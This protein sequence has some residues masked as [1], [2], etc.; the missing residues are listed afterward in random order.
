MCRCPNDIYGSA[1]SSSLLHALGDFSNS[2]LCRPSQYAQPRYC[3]T[4]LP[5]LLVLRFSSVN[6]TKARRRV[7]HISLSVRDHFL[8]CSRRSFLR[9]EICRDTTHHYR[10]LLRLFRREFLHNDRGS[11]DGQLV[12]ARPLCHRCVLEATKVLNWPSHDLFRSARLRC[13][14]KLNRWV[15]QGTSPPSHLSIGLCS[16]HL[17]HGEL[18][19]FANHLHSPEHAV[20]LLARPAAFIQLPDHQPT[21]APSLRREI[22]CAL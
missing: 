16:H 4:S 7:L 12:L 20:C 8:T 2:T 6:R 15:S 1:R 9:S 5:L 17:H 19:V 3:S 22:Y 10:H 21:S 18:A 13:R 14:T 11:D